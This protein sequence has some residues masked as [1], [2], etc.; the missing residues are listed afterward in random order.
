MKTKTT[1][2]VIKFIGALIGVHNKPPKSAENNVLNG[3]IEAKEA[4]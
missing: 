4:T 3:I 1:I 2:F